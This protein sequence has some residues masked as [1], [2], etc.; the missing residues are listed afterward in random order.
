M[1]KK[2][3]KNACKIDTR[4]KIAQKFMVLR[5]NEPGVEGWRLK[6]SSVGSRKQDV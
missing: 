3:S 5:K 2:Y 6:P 4:L 1:G